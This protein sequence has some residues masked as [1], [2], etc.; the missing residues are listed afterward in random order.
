MPVAAIA[1]VFPLAQAEGEASPIG[2]IL[3]TLVV[4]LA[5]ALLI[6][7]VAVA[8]KRLFG[9][10]GDVTGDLSLGGLRDLVRQGKMTPEEFE[11]TKAQIVAAAQRRAKIDPIEVKPIP[12]R[13]DGGGS[14]DVGPGDM[15]TFGTD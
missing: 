7:L 10:G 8:R 5:V 3:T 14:N 15:G 4:L 13:R 9:H 2:T 11:R 6:G 12:P 1:H